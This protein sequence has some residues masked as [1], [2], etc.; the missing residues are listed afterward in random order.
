MIKKM[1]ICFIC[2]EYPPGPHGGV[3]TMTQITAR[4]LVKKGHNVRVIGVYYSDYPA[5]NYEEDMGVKIWRI[6]T[7]NGKFSWILGWYSQYKKIKC[8]VNNKEIDIIEAPDS[9]GWFAFWKNINIPLVLRANGATTYFSKI[10]GTHVNK[11]TAFLEKNSYKKAFAYTSVS[12]FTAQKTSDT[13]NL[14][15]NNYKIIYNS[16]ENRQIIPSAKRHHHRIVFAGTLAKKKGI[17]SLIEALIEL[18]KRHIPFEAYIYG[19][20]AIDKESGSMLALLKSKLNP[21]I[22]N[23][24][25]F[26]NHVTR[27]ELFDSYSKATVAIFPSYAEAFAFAPMEAMLAGCPTIYSS[28]GSGPELINQNID[29]VL[30]NPDNPLEIAD[31]LEMIL[32]DETFAKKIGENGRKKILENF[33]ID[34]MVGQLETFYS[35]TIESYHQSGN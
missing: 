23:F 1:N 35:E 26:E 9:R 14:N 15:P 7:S 22:N 29:G 11:L 8:W 27:E 30:V 17:I 21:A 19:K 18:Q 25:H 13:F 6:R 32:N 10:L 33:T 4:A 12:K 3:G 28:L 5:L 20:D 24:V 34:K 16:I 31:A 2:S